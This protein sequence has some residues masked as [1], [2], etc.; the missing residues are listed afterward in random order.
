[1]IHNSDG[2]PAYPSPKRSRIIDEQHNEVHYL[3][4]GVEVFP[5]EV[6]PIPKHKRLV[7]PAAVEAARKPYSE[8]SGLPTYGAPP[9]H[10]ISVGAGGPDHPFNMIQLTGF[11]HMQA[12]NGEISRDTLF[13]II[14]RREGVT[15]EHLKSEIQRMRGRE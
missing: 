4:D 12:H 11:E 8:Y 9:H 14:A 1:M 10:V 15:V 3:E 2:T 6:T 5:E 7:D 13:G